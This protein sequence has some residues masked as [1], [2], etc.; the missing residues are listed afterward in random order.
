MELEVTGNLIHL[1][2]VR[3]AGA[4]IE[5]DDAH[6]AHLIARGLAIVP[7]T[8][9]PAAPPAEASPPEAAEQSPPD[10]PEP[11][12]ASVTERSGT[13]QGAAADKPKGKARAR[14]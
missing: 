4:L 6:G 8:K 7:G 14:K 3:P 5:V 10:E 1:G 13:S 2:N 12:Q 11:E 9:P